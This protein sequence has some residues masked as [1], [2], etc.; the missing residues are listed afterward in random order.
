MNRRTIIVYKDHES[1]NVYV[2]LLQFKSDIL[3]AVREM[4]AA[5]KGELPLPKEVKTKQQRVKRQSEDE[6]S[7]N[8]QCG[9][10]P[11]YLCKLL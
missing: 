7:D 9:S 1:F 5:K 11:R 6:S 4:I 3:L 2:F 10:E 8:Q